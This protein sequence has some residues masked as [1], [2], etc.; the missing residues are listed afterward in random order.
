M[1]SV[2][3]S[4]RG[5]IVFIKGD[6]KQFWGLVFLCSR[7]VLGSGLRLLS[8]LGWLG[9]ERNPH[10]KKSQGKEKSYKFISAV[11]EGKKI[12]RLE[13]KK[14][15]TLHFFIVLINFVISTRLSPLLPFFSGGRIPSL[16]RQSLDVGLARPPWR[17]CY[18]PTYKPVGKRNVSQC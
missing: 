13:Q 18:R 10:P 5:K 2:W 16:K 3:N 1:I 6:E 12:F 15:L 9:P 4:C 8:S 14:K 11:A 7:V 17:F